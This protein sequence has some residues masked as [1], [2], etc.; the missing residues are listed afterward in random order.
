MYYM[1]FTGRK[2][3]NVM[4][5]KGI[6]WEIAGVF[7]APDRETACLVAA[8]RTGAGTCFAIDGVAWGVDTLQ[9]DAVS[10]LGVQADPMDR[11]ERMGRSLEK[12]FTALAAASQA[13]LPSAESAGDTDGE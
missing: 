11:L 4:G 1:V 6:T 5:K 12:S 7:E 3:E 9:A 8:Q 13:Q 2:W 10:E